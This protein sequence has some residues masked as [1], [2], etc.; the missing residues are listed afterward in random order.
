V[1]PPPPF[2]L[3]IE[4]DPVSETLCS[5]EYRTT[6]KV[7]KL[8]NSECCTLLLNPLVGK[9]HFSSNSGIEISDWLKNYQFLDISNTVGKGQTITFKRGLAY[10]LITYSYVDTLYT[11]ITILNVAILSL[12]EYTLTSVSRQFGCA[13]PRPWRIKDS[14]W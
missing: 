1:P 13:L 5:L 9:K 6:D 11:D 10:Y 8:N 3:R 4:T 2:H 7:Q 12:Y 14:E